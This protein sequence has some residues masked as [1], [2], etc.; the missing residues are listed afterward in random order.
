ML[1]EYK[2]MLHSQNR[3]IFSTKLAL[4]MYTSELRGIEAF[5][6]SVLYGMD[7]LYNTCK[8]EERL[9]VYDEFTQLL[10]AF[11]S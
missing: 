11:L 5:K 3:Q 9:E 10:E 8:S 6:Q 1:R 2:R 4:N 7:M